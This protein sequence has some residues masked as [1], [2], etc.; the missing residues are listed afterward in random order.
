MKEVPVKITNSYFEN[1]QSVWNGML[2]L[3]NHANVGILYIFGQ[4]ES[5]TGWDIRFAGN[6]YFWHDYTMAPPV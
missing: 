2:H 5:P 1:D 4:R 6:V 3:A